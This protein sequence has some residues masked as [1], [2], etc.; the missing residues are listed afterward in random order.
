MGCTLGAASIP[1][2]HPSLPRWW[3][4]SSRCHLTSGEASWGQ[5]R[6]TWCQH[7]L[8]E[9]NV[10]RRGNP[11]PLPALALWLLKGPGCLC[12]GWGAIGVPLLSCRAILPPHCLPGAQARP[13]EPSWHLLPPQHPAELRGH[14]HPAPVSAAAGG[15][16][17]RGTSL[18]TPDSSLPTQAGAGSEEGGG[19]VLPF[20]L[21]ACGSGSLG[22]Q[23]WHWR[24]NKACGTRQLPVGRWC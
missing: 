14:S 21:V 16:G 1:I 5:S 6:R 13:A 15:W 3:L 2:L 10:V 7:Q 20:S 9:A 18:C 12:L 23:S 19:P 22:A 17:A 4:G 11:G 24:R 8:Q